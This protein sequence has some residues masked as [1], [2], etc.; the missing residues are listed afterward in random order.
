MCSTGDSSESF[1]IDAAIRGYHIYKEIWSNPVH[2]ERLVCECKIG[3]SHDPLSVVMKKLI[4]GNSTVVGHI[5]RHIS[6]F[7][8]IFIKRGG[9]ITCIVDG[10]RR[11]SADLA[12]GGLELPCKLLFSTPSLLESNKM[13]N[14]KEPPR[15]K[16]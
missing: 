14:G 1:V 2:E 9:S 10:L 7:C 6:P 13:K 4:E 3:N 11:Y 5:P 8:S 12:Q 16:K 15:A